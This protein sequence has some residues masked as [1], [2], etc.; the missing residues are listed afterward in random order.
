MNASK[1]VA[2]VALMLPLFASAEEIVP[3]MYRC[4][5]SNDKDQGMFMVVIAEGHSAPFMLFDRSGR[6]MN[7]GVFS[8]GMTDSGVTEYH[9]DVNTVHMNFSLITKKSEEPRWMMTLTS[10]KGLPQILECD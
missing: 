6:F 7:R 4:L 10:K 2:A 8:I 1:L 9:A 3:S 5:D